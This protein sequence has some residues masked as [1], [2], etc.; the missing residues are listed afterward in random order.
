[1]DGLPMGTRSG[2]ID[3]GAALYMITQFGLSPQELV[4][5][6]NKKSGVL[7]VSGISSDFRDLETAAEHGNERAL[8][9]RKMFTY[10][11]KKTIGSYIAALG[12]V[13]AVA[14]T[15]GIGENDE[16][17]RAGFTEG[18]ECFGIELD[19]EKNRG[20]RTEGII[21]KAGSKVTLMLV[22]TNEELMIA[23]D[24]QEIVASLPGRE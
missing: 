4:E 23:L 19:P 22:P 9:A 15:G 10:A 24:T 17:I 13:D 18:L 11:G 7:G 21:S 1:M 2:S 14:F 12:G 3:A 16:G 20:R 8:L 6:L 5:V